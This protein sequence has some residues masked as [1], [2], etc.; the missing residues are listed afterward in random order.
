[1]PIWEHKIHLERPALCDGDG[2]IAALRRWGRQFYEDVSPPP[3]SS[4][5]SASSEKEA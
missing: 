1:M 2:P 4:A 5:A 3:P